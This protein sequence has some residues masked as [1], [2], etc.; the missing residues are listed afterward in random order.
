MKEVLEKVLGKIEVSTNPYVR[1]TLKGETVLDIEI[2]RKN[3]KAKVYITEEQ[4]LV[5]GFP[6]EIHK[7]TEETLNAFRNVSTAI[8]KR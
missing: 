8:R 4:I 1:H 5:I 6:T 7:H 3:D 2:L